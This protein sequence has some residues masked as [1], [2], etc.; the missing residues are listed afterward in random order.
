MAA[1]ISPLK[2]RTFPVNNDRRSNVDRRK[3]LNRKYF[4]KGGKERRSWKERRY[5]WYMTQ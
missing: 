2:K 5:I 3:T 4:L 1:S